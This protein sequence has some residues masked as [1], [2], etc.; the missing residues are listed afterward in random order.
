MKLLFVL[1]IL[2]G[3]TPVLAAG[4]PETE[5]QKTFYAIGQTVSRQ[6]AVFGLSPEEFQYVL[7]GLTDAQSGKKAA[8]D[9][10]AYTLKVQELARDRR[11]AL[12]ARL[13]PLG[14]QT[15][16]KAAKEPGAVKTASGMVYQSL[17][18]GTGAS[19]LESDTVRV[20]YRGTLVD[21]KEFDSSYKRGKPLDLKLSGVIKCWTEGVQ[22]MKVGGKA[23][24]ICPPAL[25]YAE[26]GAGEAIP[27]QST[28]LF[29][30]ELLEIVK[31]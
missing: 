18:E 12:G 29:D 23:K 6:L 20:H 5:A 1:L 24:L 28:L 27:P 15:L 3:A 26:S 11:K 30:I 2:L 13:A 31:K 8:I 10:S 14:D 17:K 4:P 7:L 25:A 16:S 9:A 22:K 21:G 19:P